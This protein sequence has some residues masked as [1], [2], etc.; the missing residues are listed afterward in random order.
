MLA[1]VKD[2]LRALL[3]GKSLTA[4]ARGGW[5]ASG[6]ATINPRFWYRSLLLNAAAVL[7]LV[8]DATHANESR[9]SSPIL[10]GAA[11]IWPG[12]RPTRYEPINPW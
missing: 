3:R 11:S 4:V 7:G 5:Q 9:R 12:S 10:S 8:K 6:V 1:T 2:A